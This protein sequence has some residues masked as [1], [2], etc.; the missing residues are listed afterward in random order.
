M[1]HFLICSLVLWC[2]TAHARIW[3]NTATGSIIFEE[4]VSLPNLRPNAGNPPPG[5]TQ[6]QLLANLEDVHVQRLAYMDQAGV[7]YMVLS[8]A[9]P[10]I[11]GVSDPVEAETLATGANNDLAA[12]ISNNTLRFGAF[13]ALAMH[14]ATAAGIELRR[15]VTQLGFLG[16]LVND[17]QQSGAD[18]GKTYLP[19]PQ[20]D[21]FWSVIEELDVPVYFHPRSAI[22]QVIA[23]DYFHSTWIEGAPHQ[24]A[25]MLSNHIVGLCAN[26]VFDRFPKLKVIVGHLGE[27]IPSDFWRID[28]MLARKVGTGM[29]MNKTFSSYWKTN[30]YETTS[31]NFATDLLDF[32]TSQIGAGQILYS[33]DYPFVMMEQGQE[34]VESLQM[35]PLEKWNFIKG[36][37]IQLLGLDR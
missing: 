7:D 1:V 12:L 37:A 32:H 25:V 34:W 20:Y 5:V 6:A 24:F 33:V 26:G 9:S 30:I 18:N 11:Q 35:G 22:A 23:L 3:N 14:N 17:Y 13:A 28:E 8:C 4:A 31:G 15:A 21:A 10:C 27:R 29:P 16:A 36:N 19:D 2:Y